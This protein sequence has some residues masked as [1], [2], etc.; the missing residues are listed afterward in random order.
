MSARLHGLLAE[1]ADERQLLDAVRRTREEGYFTSCIEAY[2]PYQVEGLDKALGARHHWVPFWMLIGAIGGGAF[3]YWLEWYSAV[4]NYPIN[5][6]GRPLFSWPAFIPPAVEM[7]ILWAVL[8]GV[9]AVLFGAR[10]PR[11]RH[12]LFESHEFERATSDRFFLLVRGDDPGFDP[13]ATQAFLEN[14]SPLSVVEVAG[15]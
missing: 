14:L 15:E 5:V 13:Q 3:T 9:G 4:V 1:F 7:T 8:F 11:V 12:P 6:G 2:S 10:L